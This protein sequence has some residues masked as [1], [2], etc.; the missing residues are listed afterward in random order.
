MLGAVLIS[1]KGFSLIQQPYKKELL[2]FAE[3]IFGMYL[4]VLK[5]MVMMKMMKK[6]IMIMMMKMII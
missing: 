6:M 5:M 1:L 2:Y 3:G 4:L